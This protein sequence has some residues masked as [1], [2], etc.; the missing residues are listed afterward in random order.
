MLRGELVPGEESLEFEGLNPHGVSTLILPARGG[1]RMYPTP[2]W[3][4]GQGRINPAPQ[5]GGW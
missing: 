4:G 1:G 5:G 3:E 2:T